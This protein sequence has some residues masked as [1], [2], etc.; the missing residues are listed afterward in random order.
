[1]P[2]DRHFDT[3]CTRN[4]KQASFWADLSE[5]E[6]ALID[7]RDRHERIA[8]VQQ[9]EVPVTLDGEP[10]VINGCDLPRPRVRRL[11]G[12]GGSVEYSWYALKFILSHGGKFRS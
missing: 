7:A 9:T 8:M 2:D 11:D 5:I 1:M 3:H 12:V 4:P 10:A 6:V